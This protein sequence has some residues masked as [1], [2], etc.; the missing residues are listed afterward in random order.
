MAA[1]SQQKALRTRI[2][3]KISAPRVVEPY[4][5]VRLFRTMDACQG[6]AIWIPAP[7]GAG[8]TCLVASYLAARRRPSLWY[9][10]DAR[11][12]D[13]A[14]VF[15]YL[16]M[17]AAL[18]LPRRKIRLPTFGPQN[19]SGVA[20]FARGFFE[21]LLDQLAPSTALVFD[22]YHEASSEAWDLVVRE[23]LCALPEGMTAFLCGRSEPSSVFARQIA[24]EDIALFAASDL[25]LTPREMT[26]VVRLRR[27]DLRGARLKAVLPRIMELANGWA[28]ALAL[29]L[30]DPYVAQIDEHGSGETPER[31]FEYFAAEVIDKASPAE[32]DFLLRSAVV[33]SLTSSLA[34]RLTGATDA[35]RILADLARRSF[36]TQRLGRSGAYRYHPLLRSFLLRRAE[37]ELGPAALQDLH[38]RAV[39]VFIADGQIDEAIDQLDAAQDVLVRSRLVLEAAP[40]YAAKGRTHSIARW[41]ERLPTSIVETNGW[42]SYWQAVCSM[43]HSPTKARQLLELAFGHFLRDGDTAGRYAACGAGIQ[44]VVHEGMNFRRLDAWIERFEQLERNQAVCPASILPMATMGMC[45]GYIFR[46]G[47][48]AA[49]RDWVKKAYEHAI[50]S[51]DVNYRVM[52]GGL[53]ALHFVV[54]D[55]PARAALMVSMLRQSAHAAESSALPA[56]TLLMSDALCTWVRG[57][58]EKCI[59]LAREALDL[60]RQSGVSVW[61]DYV[62]TVGSAAAL[63]TDRLD[64]AQEFLAVLAKSAESGTTFSVGS[65]MY[66]LGWEAYLRGDIARALSSAELACERADALGD[67]FPRAMVRLGL[68]QTQ[69]HSG[70]PSEAIETLRAGRQ[71]AEG[72]GCGLVQHACDLVE[73][74]FL[75]DKSRADAIACLERGLGLAR[76]RA[77]HNMFWL[78]AATMTRIAARALENGIEADFVRGL[79]AK[80]R[81]EPKGARPGPDS[82]FWRYRVRALG[83]FEL[84]RHE[85]APDGE[86]QKTVPSTPALRGMPLRLLKA[87]VAQG[88]RRVHDVA[89]IDALWPDAE[90]DAGRRVF[91]TTLHRLRR[92]LG[93]N[94]MIHLSDGIVSLDEGIC[95]IDV[96]ALDD[97]IAE[98]KETVRGAPSPASL[99]QLA[100]RLLA[101]YRGPLLA[102]DPAA[103]GFSGRAR[104]ALAAQFATT[105]Q[106]LGRALEEAGAHFEAAA[107]YRRALE[108]H[109][110]IEWIRVGIE[111]CERTG[112]GPREA[113]ELKG[114]L[115]TTRGAS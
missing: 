13:I 71:I 32:R 29:L 77:Y 15:H 78:G 113:R 81:L 25:L 45:M 55:E 65:Y 12:A 104:A 7:A 107:L 52:T 76:A 43:G 111:R 94:D 70:R 39:E 33:P 109:D 110:S 82:W 2:P 103:S 60:A 34:A 61:S 20:A 112:M 37:S 99:R 21:A 115:R 53:L 72:V 14:N 54:Y 83:Q 102:D 41:I 114:R 69:W 58:N 63:A 84:I 68:A 48:A 85:L 4:Q 18:A 64:V 57:N 106:I 105:A 59:A 30:Q 1:G 87:I 8:K 10:V 38:R 9:N 22:D 26:G 11:D 23:G 88:G 95:W 93:E 47:G 5:R 80:R 46:Q 28:A 79:I 42:F 86:P 108:G 31:L 62:A 49:G 98:I 51:D 74:D 96:W 67:P 73:S 27:P 66:Q 101:I 75:W 40:S 56:L 44:A 17:A 6:R 100:D 97:A 19:Q 36:L 16:A 92:Q 89:L 50:T 91:D 24:A 90:G 35:G 3:A